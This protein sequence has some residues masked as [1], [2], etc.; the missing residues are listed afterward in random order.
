MARPK[1]PDGA[2][3]PLCLGTIHSGSTD[4]M[5]DLKPGILIVKEVPARICSLCGE[6]WL[7]MEISDTLDK[8]VAKMRERGAH[9]EIIPY[10]TGKLAE[11]A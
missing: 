11:V 9:L 3:C 10:P 4:F 6:E 8:L 5:V 7:D 1:F 2:E